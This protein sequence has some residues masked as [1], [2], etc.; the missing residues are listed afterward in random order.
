MHTLFK[1]YV[2]TKDKKCLM[3]FKNASSSD[4]RTYEQ[5]ENLPEYAGIIDEDI[6]LIDVDDY[7]QSEILMD[8][9]EDL[10]LRCRV[11]QTT[12]GKHFFF[13]NKDTDGQI[14]QS[15]CKVKKASER[16]ACGLD[17]DI[18]VGCKNSYSILK[19]NGKEREI[20]YDIYSDE[21]YE[22]VPKWLLPVKTNTNFRLMESG[23]GRNQAL[24]NY[25]LTLQSYDFSVDEIKQTIKIIND[26]V[27]PDKLDDSELET[28]LRDE[29]FK[30]PIFFNKSGGFLFDKF[31]N[32]IKANNHIIKV[33]DQM[34]IYKDGIYVNGQRYIEAEMIK[35]ISKLNRS[36]RAEVLSYLDIMIGDSVPSSDANL[37][38]FRNGIYNIETDE[39][40][41]FSP[42][43]VIL[44]KIDFDYIPDAYSEVAD[45]TLNK[46]ACADPEI[47]SLLEEVIGY[48]FYRR[49]ELRKSFILI[50]DKA[51]GKSTYLDMIKTLLGD[52]NTAALDLKELGDRFKTAELFGKL[53]NIGDDI[54]DE[55]IPNPAA[56]KKLVSGDRLNVERKG[57]DPFDFNNYSKLLFSANN[58]PR[59]KD[60]SGAVVDRLVII[61]F[62]AKFS[63]DDPDY[64]PYIKYK[65]RK[66]ES[67]EY[68]IQIGIEG[69]KRVLQNR[70]F[71]S[72]VK[73]AKEL[74][75]YEENN[76]P[77]LLFFK[78][79]PKIENEPTNKVYMNYS[80]FCLANSFNPMSKIEFSKQVKKRF[81]FDIVDKTIKGKKYRIFVKKEEQT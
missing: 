30:K 24:F 63:V 17:A 53:A 76:N 27:L 6:I 72:S 4:L 51:N 44:N 61:P 43:Y 48:T 68:L 79:E 37:I 8:I 55:F 52:R 18:K 42:E 75:E 62:N 34:H 74:E 23:D 73:V 77:I 15:T 19:F 1:G 21:E 28:I 40:L 70:R 47:R 31:A 3:P 64:D 59:I 58:I 26:Y 5:V 11:Y 16:L 81:D 7:D 22:P 2:P 71:T 60:K 29:A 54:G 20:I 46:L 32:Y 67:I 56:F 13:L 45:K 41:S 39:L 78:E 25:I 12:R 49:N 33:N 9:V 57:Q 69:L 36:K 65:L 66:E 35:H 10:Q 50:G 14:I 80:E 38:A